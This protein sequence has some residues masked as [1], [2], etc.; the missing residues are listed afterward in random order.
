[1]D[2]KFSDPSV[3]LQTVNWSVMDNADGSAFPETPAKLADLASGDPDAVQSALDHLDSTLL[4]DGVVY[5]ATAPAVRYV[6]ALL[7]D[8]R[9][10]KSLA[11]AWEKGKYPLR[12]KLLTWLSNVAH[13]VSVE[14]ERRIRSW[15]GHAP[16]VPYPHFLE[17]RKLYPIIFPSVDAYLSDPDPTVREAALIAAVQLLESPDLASRRQ[18]FVPLVRNFLETSSDKWLRRL[19][20]EALTAWGENVDSL[21]GVV[22]SG[23]VDDDPPSSVWGSSQ[24]P[25]D[26]PP[27]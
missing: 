22:D 21:P 11:P 7:G 10:R 20:I 4:N 3:I 14:S 27:F 8:P 12:S 25:T 18:G 23:R 9:S 1:M 24:G 15:S 26:E 17:I 19:A 2:D 6:A 16:T 13:D 5:S